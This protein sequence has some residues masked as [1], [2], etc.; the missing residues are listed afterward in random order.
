[1]TSRERMIKA[2]KK[3]E[4]DRMPITFHIFDHARFITQVYPELDPTDYS[5][6]NFKVIEISKE[7]KADVFVRMLY[8]AMDPLHIFMGG[9]EVEQTTEDWEV[10][11]EEIH[12]KN[13]IIKQSTIST[14]GGR[15]TQDYSIHTLPDGQIMYACTK[16]PIRDLRSLEIAEK[17]EPEMLED[18]PEKLKEKVKRLKESLGDDGILGVWVPNG[19]FNNASML[20]DLTELYSLFLTDY[21]LYERLMT[22]AMERV[23]PYTKAVKESGADVLIIGGN[24]PSGFVGKK[25]YD[26]YILSFEKKYVD[27]CQ[28]QGTPALYHNCGPIM[29]LV[30][31][32][33]LLGVAAVEPFT[34]PPAGDA[35]IKEAVEM[36]KGDYVMVGGIDKIHVL[37]KGTPSLIKRTVEETVMTA[38]KYGNFILQNADSLEYHTPIEN[39]KIYVETAMENAWY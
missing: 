13:T 17:Y 34:P 36:V 27:F 1:M 31:S 23:L 10:H 11:T 32:Y 29:D 15:L 2:F 38:K 39:L 28:D 14:P 7:L 8:D 12:K 30:D 3:E 9:L 24:V 22:F 19:P 26:E 33:K 16:K 35:L 20:Y 18:Y 6:I 4:T 25:F 37:Q 5:S 21:S